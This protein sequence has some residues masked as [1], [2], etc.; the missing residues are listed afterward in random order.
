M[1]APS[2]SASVTAPPTSS[3]WTSTASCWTRWS[4]ERQWAA[5]R[6]SRLGQARPARRLAVRALGPAR[7]GRLGDPRRPP[8]LHLRPPHVLGRPG[9]HDPAGPRPADR[10]TW[11]AGSGSAT[12]STPRSWSMAGTPA[13]RLHPA[14]QDP[15]AGRLPADRDTPWSASSPPQIRCGCRPWTPWT[16]SWFPTVW[17]TAMT[18][19]ASPDGLRGHEGTSRSAP[20]GTWTP[21]P[22]PGAPGGGPAGLGEDVHLRQPPGPVRR[23]DRPDR[24]AAGQFPAGLR[25]SVADQRRHHPQPPAR[26]EPRLRSCP[27]GEQAAAASRW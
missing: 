7:R 23:G 1:P 25:A 18:P 14:R 6:L 12:G 3:S 24:R 16:A 8:E 21:W 22:A 5:G 2:R 4:A 27:E 13:A 19:S 10:P 17:C 26:P 20:S 11:P 9:S 15:G